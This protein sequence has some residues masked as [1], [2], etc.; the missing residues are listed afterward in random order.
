MLAAPADE[1]IDIAVIIGEQHETLEMLRRGSGI[2]AQARQREIRSQRIE[3]G[4]RCGLAFGRDEQ[5]IGRLVSDIGQI[6][7][8]K[9]AR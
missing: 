1:F 7:G 6:G 9:M 4:E 3:Q 8:R 5:A 2:M